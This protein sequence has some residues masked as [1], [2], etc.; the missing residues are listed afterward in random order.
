MVL[1]IRLHAIQE[2]RVVSR[3]L[4]LHILSAIKKDRKRTMSVERIKSTTPTHIQTHNRW[5]SGVHP[6]THTGT[7]GWQTN[8][9]Y[10]HSLYT[11]IIK[12]VTH[13]LVK[14]QT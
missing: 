13:T 2:A 6:H 7:D 14:L 11:H 5:G 12:S 3:V 9:H 10:A 4:S 1:V 8:T